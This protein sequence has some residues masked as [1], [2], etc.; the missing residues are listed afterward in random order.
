MTNRFLPAAAAFVVSAAFALPAAHAEKLTI[1]VTNPLDG[2][3]PAETIT[4]PW[5]EVNRVLPGAA[6]QKIAVRDA[7]GNLLPYQVTN[8][9]PQAKDPENRGIAYGELI[10]QHD[11]KAGEKNATFTVEKTETV[12]PPFPTKV[13]AR[14]VQ[15][16]L[17]DF[18]W[19]NDKVAHRTYG[20]ALGAP[21]PAGG[22]KE[23]LVTSGNDIWFKRVPYPIVDR[24]YNKGHDHYHVD[25]GEG[26]DM[27]NVGRTLGAGGTGIWDGSKLVSARNYATWKVLANGPVRAIFELSYDAFD[28]AGT[29]VSEVRRFTVD[30]GHWFDRID[31][32]FTFTGM[33]QLNA[34]VGLNK[35][36]TD[37]GQDPSIATDRVPADGSLR[38]W[39]TQKSNDS[40]GVAVVVP[41]AKEAGSDGANDFVI[42]P[43]TSGKPLTYYVGAAWSRAGEIRTKEEWARQVA[44]QAARAK[45]PVKVELAAVK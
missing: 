36:P 30:A 27:Y 45:A 9:A 2:A 1:T 34:V 10:F 43:V 18:A 6:L 33:P 12:S 19:E 40:F 26:M 41:T 13:H 16:R 21:A 38:Q 17:D 20:P 7:A 15:E 42:A 25:Q 29:K 23:V 44:L 4:V 39:V 14:Y 5:S 11:F 37:K 31:S 3:R 8:V 24:W 22:G 35:T 32:T 28:A